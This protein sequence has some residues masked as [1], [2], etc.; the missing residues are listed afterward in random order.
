[1]KHLLYML[2]TGDGLWGWLLPWLPV[3]FKCVIGWFVLRLV[4][5]IY[6]APPS[7]RGEPVRGSRMASFGWVGLRKLLSPDKQRL[8]IGGV[9]L[10]R[11][12]ESLH[13]LISG[14]TGSGKSQ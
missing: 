11:K 10:P 5:R 1:M 9:A 13:L 7:P 8:R 2:W 14:S 3:L 12:L 6:W 4:Y